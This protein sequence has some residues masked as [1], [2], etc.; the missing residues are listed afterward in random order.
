M[1]Y[2]RQLFAISITLFLLLVAVLVYKR[3]DIFGEISRSIICFCP[4]Y[5]YICIYCV[6]QPQLEMPFVP[7][8]SWKRYQQTCMQ[9]L[10][11]QIEITEF[12]EMSLWETGSA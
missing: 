1:R 3:P 4:D 10:P 6:Q 2:N 7:Q 11:Y 9:T 12:E 8:I 5:L